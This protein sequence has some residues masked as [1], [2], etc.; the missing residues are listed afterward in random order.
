MTLVSYVENGFKVVGFNQL[1]QQQKFQYNAKKKGSLF[2][3]SPLF[4]LS[5]PLIIRKQFSE[6]IVSVCVG[7]CIGVCVYGC[8][9]ANIKFGE[10]WEK[11]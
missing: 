7:V 4:S 8:V 6:C 2:F 10:H 11:C 9:C 3:F 1:F 5:P